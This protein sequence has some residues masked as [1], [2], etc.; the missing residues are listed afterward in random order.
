MSAGHPDLVGTP[1]TKSGRGVGW[2]E[3]F[4]IS[5][6]VSWYRFPSFSLAQQH[7]VIVVRQKLTAWVDSGPPSS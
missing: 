1:V 6:G 5:R 3:S 7:Q 4:E 2:D